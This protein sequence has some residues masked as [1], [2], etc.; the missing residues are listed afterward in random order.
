MYLSIWHFL[1]VKSHHP[2]GFSHYL[3]CPFQFNVCNVNPVYLQQIKYHLVDQYIGEDKNN[4]EDASFVNISVV[5]LTNNILSPGLSFLSTTLPAITCLTKI[6]GSPGM[7][8]LSTPPCKTKPKSIARSAN[9]WTNTP[10][11]ESTV[12][13]LFCV[14]EVVNTTTAPK[15]HFKISLCAIRSSSCCTHSR[16]TKYTIGQEQFEEKKDILRQ[17]RIH[18]AKFLTFSFRFPTLFSFLLLWNLAN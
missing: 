11:M 3:L 14:R 15:C 10:F 7:I 12:I 16:F 6:P 4:F 9:E 5:L 13:Q 1:D 18:Y 17:C 2:F 8:S